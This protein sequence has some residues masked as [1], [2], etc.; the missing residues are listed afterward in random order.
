MCWVAADT[1]CV[2]DVDYSSLL[3]RLQDQDSQL[4][5]LYDLINRRLAE[6]RSYI[7]TWY[8]YQAL[9]D[10]DPEKGTVWCRCGLQASRLTTGWL[11]AQ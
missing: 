1:M 9:W 4:V 10:M 11:G 5:P 8:S 6:A 3:V 2:T 7:Q